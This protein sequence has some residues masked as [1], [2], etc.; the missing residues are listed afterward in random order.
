MADDLKKKGK[1][2]RSLVNTRQIHEIR[3][4]TKRFQ[5]T[6]RELVLAERC[7]SSCTPEDV[8]E[9]LVKA[10]ERIRASRKR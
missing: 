5:C 2:D 10:D 6:Q 1:E 8:G 4:W 7:A 9:Q 3:Y